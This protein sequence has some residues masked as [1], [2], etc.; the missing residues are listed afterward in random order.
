MRRVSRL[1]IALILGLVVSLLTFPV[2]SSASTCTVSNFQSG[3]GSSVDPFVVTTETHFRNIRFCDGQQKYFSVRSDIDLQNIQLTPFGSSGA[4]LSTIEGE[5]FIGGTTRSASISGINVDAARGGLISLAG[6]GTVVRNLNLSGVVRGSSNTGAV[7]ALAEPSGGTNLIK[8]DGVVSAVDVLSTGAQGVGGLVGFFGSSSYPTGTLQ[9]SGSHTVFEGG[10]GLISANNSSEVG[11]L[12]GYARFASAIDIDFST[13]A[14][15]IRNSKPGGDIGGLIGAVAEVSFDI[16]KSGSS[17]VIEYLPNSETTG[18]NVAG[19]VG[20]LTFSATNTMVNKIEQA[21]FS[22]LIRF[23][24]RGYYGGL[25]GLVPLDSAN[26]YSTQITDTYV[27]GAFLQDTSIV[28]TNAQ[29]YVGGAIG[30]V[31]DSITVRRVVLNSQITTALGA[32]TGAVYGFQN[33]VSQLSNTDLFFNSSAEAAD[34]TRVGYSGYLAGTGTNVAFTGGTDINSSQLASAATFPNLSNTVWDFCASPYLLWQ[35]SEGCKP[36]I[37]GSRISETGDYLEVFFSVPVNPVPNSGSRYPVQ[38]VFDILVDGVSQTLP[39]GIM[40]STTS[41][42]VLVALPNVIAADQ[43]VQFSYTD[44]SSSDE[45]QDLAMESAEGGYDVASRAYIFSSNTSQAA[46]QAVFG[47]PVALPTSIQI[48]LSCDGNCGSGDSFSYVVSLTPNGGSSVTLSGNST[49]SSV[50]IS[51]QSLVPNV[52]H[53]VEA[54]V[55]FEGVTGATVSQ[56]VATP[57]PI[58]TISALS[59]TDTQANVMVDC[60]NCGAAPDSYVITATPQGVGTPITSTT[61]LVNGLTAETTYSFAVVI[62]YAGVTSTSVNWQSNPVMTLPR[63]PVIAT[64]SPGAIALTGNNDIRITGSNFSTSNAV[65]LDGAAVSFTIVSG[66]EITI[67]APAKTAGSYELAITNIVGT[68]TLSNA[69][70]YVSGPRITVTSPIVGTTNGGTII[71]I[72]GTDLA[73]ASEVMIGDSTVSF[74]VE[75]DTLVRFVTPA[76]SSGAVSISVTTPGGS[77]T[78]PVAFEYTTSA[79]VPVI[80]TITPVTGPTAGGTTITVTGQYFSGSYSDS[81]SAAINGI[82]GSSVILI[83]DSTLTFVSPPG[84]AASGLDV[85]V[86]T[87]GGVGTLAGA[88]TYTAP[89][90]P[91]TPGSAPAVVINTPTITEF[92]TREISATGA[93]VTATGLRLENVS[94]LTLGGITVTIVANTATSLTFTTAEMPVGVWDLRLVGSSGTLTFQQ[95]ITVTERAIVSES[96]GELLGWTWTLKFTGNSR[97]LS[98]A[99][100]NNLRLR[101]TRFED[102]ETII[103]WGYTTAANP[104]A[105]AIAHA[106]KRAQAACDFALANQR[107]VKTVVRLR[108]GVSKDYAMRSALQFWK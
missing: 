70:T 53:V 94:V 77:T 99:Q 106:T 32:K 56:N 86:A 87:G 88:F 31:N 72:T 95:A 8:I 1:S 26:K 3:A 38:T 97:S 14:T 51:F 4:F 105:W 5:V 108:Y 48:G 34:S 16:Y 102:A 82:S 43:V 91:T 74:T 19:L 54:S 41:R 65:T 76:S 7:I 69:V 96:T 42:S 45:S 93:S 73:R 21:Y 55:T 90:A 12:L 101:L 66:T 13:T 85:R 24:G 33:N 39:S 18:T 68:Y 20:V 98:E 104:N 6:S 67:S 11:G 62:T 57:R 50:T 46:P 25:I 79:L 23:R 10:R 63:V 58:A 89:S 22:G 27:N 36:T 37:T 59:V 100:Q 30:S 60:T 84:A 47:T 28:S 44:P 107:N 64:V 40:P 52:T 75:S 2:A 92:S 17:S 29:V 61:N 78:S 71:S 15:V 81:V 49:E 35:G 103:C 9:I 83:D 80:A